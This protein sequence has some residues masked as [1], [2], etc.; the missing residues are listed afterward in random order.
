MLSL[1]NGQGRVLILT[2]LT[3]ACW[4]RTWLNR[5]LKSFNLSSTSSKTPITDQ[6]AGPGGGTVHVLEKGIYFDAL[7]LIER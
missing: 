6:G 4:S 1:I 2:V 5:V 7:E 3:G